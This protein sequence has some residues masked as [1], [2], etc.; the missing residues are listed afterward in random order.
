MKAALSKLLGL[1]VAGSSLIPTLANA[2]DRTFSSP[3]PQFNFEGRVTGLDASNARA[4]KSSFI[5]AVSFV[6][7]ISVPR[8]DVAVENQKYITHVGFIG[9]I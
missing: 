5:D 7:H 8:I 4:Y 9:N 3:S 6:F 1:L 2:D